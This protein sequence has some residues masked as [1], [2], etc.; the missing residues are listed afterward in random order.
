MKYQTE[1]ILFEHARVHLKNGDYTKAN[2]IYSEILSANPCDTGALL[3]VGAIA[4]KL[5]S[6]DLAVTFFSKVIEID[7]NCEEAFFKRGQVHFVSSNFDL[8][9]ADFTSTLQINPSNLKALNSRGIANSHAS[10]FSHALKDFGKAIQ[11]CSSNADLFYNRGLVHWNQ[12]NYAA[13]ISDY[14]CA[15]EL[16]PKYH[17]AFNNRGSAYRELAD[18]EMALTDFET[19]TNLKSDFA[20]GYWNQSLIHMMNG[21]YEKAWPLYEYRWQSK[22]FPSEKR[23][24]SEPLWLGKQSIEGKTILIHSEQGLGDT[25]Q[26][27]RYIKMLHQKKCKILMEV[28][29]PLINLMKCL[30]PQ[31]NIFQKG[32]ALPEFDSH[33]PLMSLPLAFN[34]SFETIPFSSAYLHPDPT[35]VAW[36]QKNLKSREKL[37]LGLAWRGN[38]NHPKNTQ[39]SACLHDLIDELRDDFEWFSLQIETTQEENQLISKCQNFHHFGKKIGDFA[40]TAAFC[41]S[42]DAIISVDTSIAHLAG[43]LGLPTYLLLS[44]VPDSRWQIMGERTPWYDTMKLFR[45]TRN[46]KFSELLKKIQIEC[47]NQ[48]VA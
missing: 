2:K 22:H 36:W 42:L 24:F 9:I 27:C 45:L 20:D 38:P 34:T 13:A 4:Q 11:I 25:I 28:E 31:E 40:E 47:A 14:T 30:L 6:V 17:Q 7:K 39:R 21:K 15:I 19:S 33:C 26:F 23:N 48:L 18:F 46:Q 16:R 5:G 29:K 1:S 43:A 44:G 35:R 41:C 8:A 10:H 12:R 37:K 3:G 32:S